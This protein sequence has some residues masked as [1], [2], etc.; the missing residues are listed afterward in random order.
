VLQLTKTKGLNMGMVAMFKMITPT[1]LKEIRRNPVYLEDLLLPEDVPDPFAGQIDLEKSWHSLH[2]MLTGTLKP[3]GTALGDALMGGE[4]VGR[5]RCFGYDRPR[6]IDFDR[7][8]E[9]NRAL[10]GL[11]FEQLYSAVDL[12]SPLLA[13]VYL[14]QNLEDDKEYL[15]HYFELLVA[16]YRTAAESKS[17]I[18][19][20]LT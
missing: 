6:L 4:E 2:F 9:I 3:D 20:Y 15:A 17:A 19:A 12:Q 18:V 16:L 1:E 11:D 5:E 14:G 7:V 8:Q 10:S 13:K